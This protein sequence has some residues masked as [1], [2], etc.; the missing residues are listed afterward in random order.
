MMNSNWKFSEH[1]QFIE[2]KAN[3]VMRVLNHLMPNLRDPDKRRQRL[4]AGVV[5]SVML[6]GA[7][8]WGKALIN[9]KIA[10]RLAFIQRTK[11]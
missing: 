6:Y 1:I 11:G 3:R 4:Y 2:E 10:G 7:P 5:T 9:N 8:V